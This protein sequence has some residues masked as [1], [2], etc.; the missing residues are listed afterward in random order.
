MPLSVFEGAD[1]VALGHLHLAQSLNERI[2]YSGSPIPLSMSERHY[3]HQVIELTVADGHVQISDRIPVPLTVEMIRIPEQVKPLETVLAKL[4]ELKLEDKA[5]EQRPFLE[6]RVLLDKPQPR[7]REQILTVI[8]DKP[9]R[10]ARIHTEYTGHGLGAADQLQ[11]TLEHLDASDVFRL[12]YQR[13]YQQEPEAELMEC[14]ESLT[15]AL[16]NQE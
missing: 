1:Y 2:A 3:P 11:T 12:C 4:A 10:L 5:V 8:Q 6:V 7:L 15:Q 14:F 9:V 13:Q 16:E